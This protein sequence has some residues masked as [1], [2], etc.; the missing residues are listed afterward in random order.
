MK[1][2]LSVE[3]VY[4]KCECGLTRPKYDKWYIERKFIK[5]HE[6]I[7]RKA[8]N[9]TKN[10]MRISQTGK[11]MSPESI[12]KTRRANIGRKVTEETKQNISKARKGKMT[13]ENHFAWK[14]GKIIRRGYIYLLKPG[15]P[16]AEMGRYIRE[17]RYVMEQYLGRLLKSYE[18]V[19][20]INGN[21][22]DN[23][24]EN[25]EVLTKSEHTKKHFEILKL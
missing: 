13:G 10:K 21:K 25:L 1:T 2:K 11:K 3:F 23:R 14:G 17:H 4:C 5:G 7:G 6:C 19:H 24:L 15:Y 9:E 16:N 20:H 22:L 8:S 18:D 12:E